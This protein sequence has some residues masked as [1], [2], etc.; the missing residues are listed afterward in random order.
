VIED[1]GKVLELSSRWDDTI[2][3]G[4]VLVT[5]ITKAPASRTRAA[6]KNAKHVITSP[7][8]EKRAQSPSIRV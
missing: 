4:R 1:D 7:A 6:T 8:A 2:D 5:V 3:P